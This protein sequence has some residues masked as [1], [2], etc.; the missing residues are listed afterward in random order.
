MSETINLT[1]TP[2]DKFGSRATAKLRKQGQVPAVIY[3][4]K[5]PL[6]HVSVNRDSLSKAIITLHA[7]TFQLD[8]EGKKET[9]LIKD[10]Q[11][12][13]LGKEMLHVDFERHSLTEKVVVP[14][15]IELRNSPKTTGGAAVDQP[16]H[17]VNVE[18]A[19]KDIPEAIR[20]D[21]TELTLGN[22]IHVK[23]LP[24]PAGVVPTD[25]AEAVVVQLRLPGAQE[26]EAEPGSD[27]P[28]VLT[29]KAKDE[30]DE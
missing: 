26:V 11:W 29:K 8:L 22:P 14:V 3:G 24:F 19:M 25:D 20:V 30:G 7:R 10:L 21:I 6:V 17:Q 27:E 16:L 5:E 4:H 18:C 2:R 13:F 1:V 12:D 28:E 9:V 23:E 15:P